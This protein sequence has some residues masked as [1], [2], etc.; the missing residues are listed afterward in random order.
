MMNLRLIG[1]VGAAFGCGIA[2]W[3]AFSGANSL[4]RNERELPIDEPSRRSLGV[5]LVR[6]SSRTDD[7]VRW[8]AENP[9]TDEVLLRVVE[10]ETRKPVADATVF[11]VEVD[12]TYTFGKTDASGSIRIGIGD[13]AIPLRLAAKADHYSYAEVL[14]VDRPSVF[15]IPLPPAHDLRG[16]IVDWNGNPVCAEMRVLAIQ[17]GVGQSMHRVQR[18]LRSDVP[19]PGIHWT[20]SNRSGEFVLESVP[21]S[22]SFD[23]MAAGSGYGSRVPTRCG[24]VGIDPKAAELAVSV[25][26]LYG[27]QLVA[28]DESGND[29]SEVVGQAWREPSPP[30]SS[31]ED[32]GLAEPSS[33]MVAL[34]VGATPDQV[35][36]GKGVG[37]VVLRCGRAELEAHG[38]LDF[39]FHHPGYARIAGVEPL[40]RVRDSIRRVDVRVTKK[41]NV[42]FGNLLV[43]LNKH[44][45][46]DH[47]LIEHR[48]LA[49]FGSIRLYC[50]DGRDPNATYHYPLRCVLDEYQRLEHVPIGTYYA[51]VLIEQS[52][53]IPEDPRTRPRIVVS[54]T[55]SSVDFDLSQSAA[56]E[57]RLLAPEGQLLDYDGRAC[58]MIQEKPS[59]RFIAGSFLAP[60][61]VLPV[62]PEGDFLVDVRLDGASEF[63]PAFT[64]IRTRTLFRAE[65]GILTTVDI[66]MITATK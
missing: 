52:L 40:H 27:L 57:L 55:E 60:P 38:S 18:A 51:E 43:R 3:T 6:E 66:P 2:L 15:E 20:T 47:R 23:V 46:F 24:K 45:V 32:E 26:A 7:A 21:A 4:E 56:I 64:M 5:H 39:V 62:V 35:L 36:V 53:T 29:V 9:T 48:S 49:A 12:S 30:T 10:Q 44:G 65:P 19:D 61:Y 41:A 37:G 17:D 28:M 31:V 1:L 42:E 59:G 16:R 63:G 34:L 13:G 14:F 22:A 8:V 50:A 25:D 58:F 54:S 33:P 11:R